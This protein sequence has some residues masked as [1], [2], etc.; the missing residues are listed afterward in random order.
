MVVWYAGPPTRTLMGVGECLVD[1]RRY[2]HVEA[3]CELYYSF[4]DGYYEGSPD[5]GTVPDRSGKGHTAN[6]NGGT[7]WGSAGVYFDGTA[8]ILT[9]VGAGNALQPGL[10]DFSVFMWFE[11]IQFGVAGYA[12]VMSRNPDP[13]GNMLR[14]YA[15]D[16]AIWGLSW[17]ASV[18]TVGGLTYSCQ[19]ILP[20]PVTGTWYQMSY[21]VDRDVGADL[22]IDGSL[23]LGAGG[24]TEAS[25]AY[26]F[27][28]LWIPGTLGDGMRF[29]AGELLWFTSYKDAAYVGSYYNATK[30]NYG[31]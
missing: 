18:D 25:S 13:A 9:V 29:M 22:Y 2:W 11:I 30:E 14:M 28:H 19:P 5:F 24:P 17:D 6:L 20:P 3:D 1:R 7:A 23:W 12:M 16:P 21:C 10:N 4:W 15:I 31:L 8:S 26:N 27:G